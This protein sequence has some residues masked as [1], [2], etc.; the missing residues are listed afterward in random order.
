MNPINNLIFAVLFLTGCA[1]V[2]PLPTATATPVPTNTSTQIPT[3][4]TTP[5]PTLTPTPVFALCS[6]IEGLFTV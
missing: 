1:S 3:A 6:P 4:T 5:L 2:Q